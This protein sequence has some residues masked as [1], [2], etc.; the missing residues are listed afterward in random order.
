MPFMDATQHRAAR[1]PAQSQ[2]EGADPGRVGA[3]VLGRQLAED[4]Y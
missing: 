4:R 3:E 2:P 1:E